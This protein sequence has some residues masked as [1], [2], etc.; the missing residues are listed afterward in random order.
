MPKLIP[1]KK[2]LQDIEALKSQKLIIRKIAKALAFLEANPHHPGLNL[3]RIINDPSA[4]SIRVDRSYR[5]SF[6]PD[7]LLPSGIP[8]WS[9]SVI[10]LRVLAH[11]DLYKRPC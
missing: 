11:D 4:W 3:E 6:D 7:K 9:H 2:F 1:S 8:D 5:I 10:L